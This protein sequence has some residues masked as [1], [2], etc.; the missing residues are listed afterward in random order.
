MLPGVGSRG[1]AIDELALVRPPRCAAATVGRADELERVRAF[2]DAHRADR[3]AFAAQPP[4]SPPAS[5]PVPGSGSKPGPDGVA[6]RWA[7]WTWARLGPE[8]RRHPA[9][10]RAV[11]VARRPTVR[12]WLGLPDRTA[13][14]SRPR[15][16]GSDPGCFD[17]HRPDANLTLRQSI[18]PSLRP[19]TVGMVILNRNGAARLNAMLES[20][21][22]HFDPSGLHVLVVDNGST[23]DSLA[24]VERFRSRLPIDGLANRANL[25]FSAAN[26]RGAQHLPPTDLLV[27][28]NNDLLFERDPLPRFRQ[29]LSDP[30]IGVASCRLD[31]PPHHP[32]HPGQ[33]QHGGIKFDLD[34]DHRMRRPR[35]LGAPWGSSW[36]GHGVERMPAVTAALVAVRREDFNRQSGFDED[37]VYGF[38]D[39]DFCLR[40]R[41]D[42]GLH[43][44]IDHDLR[45]LHDESATQRE[46]PSDR[47]R[48]QRVRN[49]HL[50][51][52]KLGH[53][54][55]KE[56]MR[57]ML[58][59]S[60]LWSD[61]PLTVG[62]AVTETGPS[63]RAGDTFSALELGSQL[64]EQFGW[65]IRFLPRKGGDWYDV[66][67][68]HVLVALLHR[69]D[70]TRMHHRRPD[71]LTVA[72]IR[73]YFDR[74]A[75][76]PW[77]HDWDL[78]LSSSHGGARFFLDP[79][80]RR[81][82]VLPLAANPDRFQHG[83]H[84]SELASDCAF[85]GSRWG[86]P[87]GLEHVLEPERIHGRVA[88]FG[89]GWPEYEPL[90]PY[91]RGFVRYDELADVYASTRV[92]LD[93]ATEY[94]RPWG[95]LNSR[96]FDAAA[97]GK[98][99]VTNCEDGVRE[100]FSDDLPTY[101]DGPSLTA[102]VNRLLDEPD[103]HRRVTERLSTEV[104]RHHTYEARAREFRRELIEFVDRRF[105]FAIKARVPS[106]SV[107]HLH[108]DHH[109]AI[110]LQRALTRLGHAARV[111]LLPDWGTP[112]A[113]GDDVSICLRGLDRYEPHPAHINVLWIISH[114][115][116]VDE[117]ELHRYDQVFVASNH[118]A[119]QW[120]Q[121]PTPRPVQP[122]L[123]C[124]DP[125]RFFPE[126]DPEPGAD[127][128]PVPAIELLFVGNGKGIHR[129][130][131]HD[132]W[133][134]DLPLTLFG[135]A[136]EGR[137][138]TRFLA[139][140]SVPNQDL[141]RYYGRCKILLNDHWP[142][143]R[144]LGYLSNR[145]F[146]AAACG[147]CIVSDPVV[148]LEEVFGDAITTYTEPPQ[149][150]DIVE[151][152]LR[153]PERRRELGN[154]ARARVA[155]DHVFERRAAR[156]VAEVQSIAARRW[157]GPWP[158]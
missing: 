54:I 108:G 84:R 97:A 78:V 144:E 140:R 76:Q 157:S 139:G 114:P 27:F 75:E 20:M 143:M 39:V 153:R 24:V 8:L 72:W 14:E 89:G 141:R 31:H 74:W 122:L 3:E 12:R 145:L 128:G 158:A 133:T 118:H 29:L 136:W 88:L 116:L 154:Q 148:G 151:D 106:P 4:P 44:V 51:D 111:D 87:R 62:F 18:E 30:R 121:L 56:Q 155:D 107:A 53:A 85:T 47:V 41:R 68:I 100:L 82:G 5:P 112:A 35:N 83:R 150:R 7:R 71:L 50:L 28:A 55:R 91:A 132:A 67:G 142:H 130:I 49:R 70:L 38:E 22:A 99:V 149:L 115:E 92:V 15:F 156:I 135:S 42:R 61:E 127:V 125:R 95:S 101:R 86:V 102:A 80:D 105:R 137:I 124:Y 98:P 147:A 33:L 40:M 63:A 93:D 123:Q 79:H 13:V 36:R 64:A 120:S 134:Q 25:S 109:F 48:V 2:A 17:R 57:S 65:R 113:V 26:N 77:F 131:V 66:R 81:A 11:D 119:E 6:R 60:R 9:V 10:L 34:L 1:K 16:A 69:Y 21:V 45:A 96:F 46:E 19:S 146:D 58:T 23:D 32:R 59:G 104:L 43:V 90:A 129:P 110:G 126:P 103:H 152:L 117:I 138:P 73:S 94:C 37:Y 52:R